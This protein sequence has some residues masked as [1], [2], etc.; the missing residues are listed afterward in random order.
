MW[1]DLNELKTMLEINLDDRSEDVRLSFWLKMAC[2][3]L[4]QYTGPVFRMERTEYHG[5]N[6]TPRLVLKCRP[7]YTNPIPRVWVDRAGKF[8]QASGSFA[9]V[10]ELKFGDDFVLWLDSSKDDTRSDRAILLRSAGLWERVGVRKA[11][12]LSPYEEEN[13]GTIKVVYTGGYYAED[14][15]YDMILACVQTVSRIR[16]MMPLGLPLGSDSDKDG[17][18]I[19]IHI[20]SNERNWLIGQVKHLL[21]NHKGSRR[22]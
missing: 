4:E 10:T 7:A 3:V 14:L 2:A 21:W 12:L 8:G 20:G 16:F 17:R 6:G 9:A 19:T 15:P 13:P 1:S 11:G 18:N 22:F 5:G